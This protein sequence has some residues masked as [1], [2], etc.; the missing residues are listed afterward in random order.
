MDG[1]ATCEDAWLKKNVRED[2]IFE[3]TGNSLEDHLWA[4]YI[5]LMEPSQENHQIYMDYYRIY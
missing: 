4:E 2:K 1:R 3:L 5:D